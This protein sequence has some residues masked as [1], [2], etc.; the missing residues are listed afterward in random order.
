MA[1]SRT[2]LAEANEL[3]AAAG[4][5][6]T[7]LVIE[8]S[9]PA[10]TVEPFA[11][12]PL[13]RPDGA[14]GLIL[15][16]AAAPDGATTWHQVVAEHPGLADFARTNWLGPW[17]RLEPLVDV[18]VW[19]ATRLGLHRVGAY[20]L[21]PARRRANTKIGLRYTVGGFGTPWFIDPETGIETQ[22]RVEGHELVV[23]QGDDVR[24]TAVTTLR[25]AGEFVGIEPD[26]EWAS[27]FDIPGPGDLDAEL[28]IDPAAAA[29]LG[30]WYGLAHSVLEELRGDADSVDPSFPQLWPEHFDP[31]I[32]TGSDE[33]RHRASFGFSP[34]DAEGGSPTP[35]VYVAAWYPD[36][37][38]DHPM[39]NSTTYRGALL[40]YAELVAADDQRATALAFLRRG[41]DQLAT[42]G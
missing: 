34:G 11:D 4:V 40:P 19:S 22:L 3:L 41:R 32:E 30:A 24:R 42:I 38:P 37:V 23:Q 1:T 9:R 20:V 5:D 33:A 10:V 18:D 13:A 7:P 29:A 8:P 17:P 12:D 15:P 27:Q 35:Y 21:S 36:A 6:G 25:A 14:T 31:A 39:W 28:G 2:T 26:V 16:Q